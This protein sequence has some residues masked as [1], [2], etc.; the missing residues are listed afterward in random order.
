[1]RELGR[2]RQHTLKPDNVQLHIVRLDA[3]RLD[4]VRLDIVRLDIV[5]LDIVRL[6]TVPIFKSYIPSR[7]AKVISCV[8]WVE[9][10]LVTTGGSQPQCSVAVLLGVLHGVEYLVIASVVIQ[11]EVTSFHILEWIL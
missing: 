1:M 3:V 7:T 9:V 10:G 4:A 11:P 2:M 5:R 6:D 8:S